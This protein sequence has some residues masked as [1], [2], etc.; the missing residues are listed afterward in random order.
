MCRPPNLPD[1]AVHNL[2][3][4]SGRLSPPHTNL[5]VRTQV[6]NRGEAINMGSVCARLVNG[7][8]RHSVRPACATRRCLAPPALVPPPTRATVGGDRRSQPLHP[9]ASWQLRDVAVTDAAGYILMADGKRAPI[10]H[11]HD[12]CHDWFEPWRQRKFVNNRTLD[13][14]PAGWGWP[15]K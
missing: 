1:Q 3:R 9:F 2:L 5:D 4:Y 7:Q 6:Y 8:H 10:V 13:A 14:L 11:Q 15:R 12:R